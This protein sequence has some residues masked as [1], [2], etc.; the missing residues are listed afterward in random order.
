MRITELLSESLSGQLLYHGGPNIIDQFKIPPF[1]VFFTP[2][3]AWAEHYGKSVT[4][5]KV[6]ATKVYTVDSELSYKDPNSFDAKVSDSLFDRDYDSLAKYIKI[7]QSKGYQALQ[8]QTDSEMICVFPGTN[9]Q[10]V[11]NYTV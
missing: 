7:L 2:H 8:T 9:I 1:G 10:V 4:V 11:D 3:K 6:N 5:A